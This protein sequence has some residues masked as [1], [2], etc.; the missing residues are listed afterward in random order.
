MKWSLWAGLV[1][2]VL[3]AV[4]FG[5][6]GGAVPM[7]LGDVWN[8]LL[9]RGDATDVAIVR[10]LRLPRVALGLVVG[11]GLAASGTALQ[12]SMAD[13][14]S[15]VTGTLVQ[16]HQVLG[17]RLLIALLV[18]LA[19]AVGAAVAH[20]RAMTWNV[21]DRLIRCRWTGR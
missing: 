18:L 10:A 6:A 8:A 17:E 15:G 14:L 3:L 19:V 5:I 7:P 20:G 16:R 9:G 1:A 2:A 13:Q 21:G 12:A 11:A 4:L